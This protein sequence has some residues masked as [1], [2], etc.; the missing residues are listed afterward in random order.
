MKAARYKSIADVLQEVK[1]LIDTHFYD[2][3]YKTKSS[4]FLKRMVENQNL[5]EIGLLKK[6]WRTLNCTPKT[7]KVIREIQENLLCVGKRREFVTKK[8]VE[9][10]C[11]CSRT[12]LRL[13]V[14]SIIVS[15]KKATAEIQSFKTLPIFFIMLPIFHNYDFLS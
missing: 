10:K 14:K 5:I 9:T 7:L 6:T 2:E 8:K 13:S 4:L 1:V 15:C 3:F 11:W 12:G